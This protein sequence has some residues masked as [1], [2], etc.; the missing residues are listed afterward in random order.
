MTKLFQHQNTFTMHVPHLK[1]V[2]GIGAITKVCT[3][4]QL[5]FQS[6]LNSLYGE[7]VT[8]FGLVTL[9]IREHRYIVTC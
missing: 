9:E 5:R 3:I 7:A 6:L 8:V 2:P 4:S 1:R